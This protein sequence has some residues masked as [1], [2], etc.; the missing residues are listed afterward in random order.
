MEEQ[1][2]TWYVNLQVIDIT[3]IDETVATDN[4]TEGK[5]I[6]VKQK[7]PK[8]RALRHTMREREEDKD[9]KFWTLI[10][11]ERYDI[12]Q[13]IA[14]SLMPIADNGGGPQF[15]YIQWINWTAQLQSILN[16]FS[17]EAH[18]SWLNIESLF[19]KWKL[20]SNL[21]LYLTDIKTLRKAKM[22][23]LLTLFSL[24]QLKYGVMCIGI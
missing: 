14:L 23:Y 24:I 4:M 20:P 5:Q 11:I 9:L 1:R 21:Y 8:N 17:P 12:N 22:L 16:Y 6:N 3:M 15:P 2:A 18:P 13:G 7:R 19:I 10:K